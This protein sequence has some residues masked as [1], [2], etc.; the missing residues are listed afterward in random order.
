MIKAMDNKRPPVRKVNK[1][2]AQTEDRKIL[3]HK[4]KMQVMTIGNRNQM[5]IERY[6]FP[7]IIFVFA[8]IL[9]S[10]TLNYFY[11]LDD[12]MVSRNNVFVQE[13]FKGILKI[14]SKGFL[15]GFNGAN[16]QSYRP[17]SLLSFA[18][19]VGLWGEN[20]KVHHFFNVFY[21]GIDCI[22]LFFLLK[23]I[24]RKQSAILP[25]IITLLFVAHPIHTEDVANFKSRDEVLVLGFLLGALI[26]VFNYQD[27]R[28]VS[29]LVSSVLLFFMALLTKEQ[30]IT[31]IVIIPLFLF[32]FSNVS[33]KRLILIVVPFAVAT[34]IYMAMR[35]AILDNITF[36]GKMTILNNG[37]A[38]ATNSSDQL[39]TA[40]LILGK[41]LLLL[42]FPHPL[43]WDY[44]YP[45]IPIVKFTNPWV[46][47]TIL[48]YAA[49]SVY[50]IL[51]LIA[52]DIFSFSFIFFIITISVV[53]N[54]FI[55]IGSTL[56]ERFLLT[57][58]IAFC[59]SIVFL[60]GKITKVNFSTI[61]FRKAIPFLT[62]ISV[63]LI[64]YSL[65]TII[66]NGDWKNNL[67]LFEAGVKAS[68]NS[69]RAHAS[70]AFEYQQAAQSS[71]D[72]YTKQLYIE[73][74]H[75]AFTKSLEIYPENSY[76]SYNLGVLEYEEGNLSEAEKLYQKT[77]NVDPVDINA[78]TNLSVI[79]FQRGEYDQ[80]LKYFCKMDSLRPNNPDIK[81]SI[82]AVY[83]RKGNYEKAIAYDEQ[84]ISLNSNNINLYNN[85]IAI[86]MHLGN[87]EKVKWYTEQKKLHGL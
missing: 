85:L 69:S 75:K 48:I 78:L 46:I 87:Q 30:A 71:P 73:K 23:R 63:L 37:L 15:Y 24:F 80:A 55:L 11:A 29:H 49:L 47:L 36:S 17:L 74:A 50:A 2:K 25:L 20:P 34:G 53:S 62:L 8:F 56:G 45:Q 18:I 43:S 31:F 79:L 76:A 83:Q 26:K 54:I 5:L 10:N 22:L 28:K 86:Y 9:Y 77:L 68:P 82:G 21:Y 65:K 52:K 67:T 38:A 57:P 42:I 19:E 3:K 61:T 4:A 81:V 44:S 40:I 72:Q 70:L 32:F 13:G 41:Y 12:D 51:R 33:V 14:F 84:A 6:L 64:L 16:D 60:L 7:G 66:R 59:I 35:G 39:A 1:G 27:N 58:S